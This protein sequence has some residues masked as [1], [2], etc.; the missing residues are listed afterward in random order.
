MTDPIK[1]IWKYKNNNRRSQYAMYIFVGDVAKPIKKILD[2]IAD[3]NFYDSLLNL[4][5]EEYKQLEKLYSDKWYN[6]LFNMYHINSSIY[7]IKDSSVLK[8][9]LVQKYSQQWFDT[10]IS[11][12]ELIEKKLIYSYESIIKYDLER[13]NKKK[14]RESN[15][16]KEAE[17]FNDYTTTKKLDVKKLFAIKEQ[18]KGGRSNKFT[19]LD[20][21]EDFNLSGG[22]GALD[23]SLDY[24]SSY[25][26]SIYG[27]YDDDHN[28]DDHD[29]EDIYRKNKNKDDDNQDDDEDDDDIKKKVKDDQE[30]DEG[31]DDDGELATETMSE[32]E[33]VDLNEIEQIYKDT[34]AK[35]D[36]NVTKT[37]ALIKE[38]LND[39]KIFEKN[40]DNMISFDQ[41]KDN[42]I[43]DENIKDIFKKHYVTSQYIFKDDTIKIIKDKICTSI[44][45]NASFGDQSY[46]LPSR[47]YLWSEYYYGDKIEKIM[48]GQKWLRRNE[49]LTIDIE[50]NNNLRLYEDLEGQ[51]KTLR[52]N[53]KRYTSKIR[54]E[55]DENNILFDYDDYI[56]NNEIYMLDLYNEFGKKYKKDTEVLKNLQDV[57]LK[58]YFPKVRT[59]ELKNILD[60]LNNSDDKVE[61]Q[62][63]I[64]VYE[65][66]S[67]DLI[68]ENEITSMVENIKLKDNFTRGFKTTYVIQSIIHLKLRQ[69][70]PDNKI[71]LYR[72]F[73]EFIVDKKYPFISY[74]TIDGN[75]VYKS[76]EQM[77][78]EFMKKSDN[79]E[80]ITK[81]YE[82]VPYGISIKFKI[83]DKFGE[84]FMGVTISDSGRI[85][86]KIVW[87]EE[88]MAVIEDIK[89][90]YGHVRDIIKKINLEKNRHKFEDPEDS[91]FKYAFINTIQQFEL[92]EK[93]IIDHNDLSDFSRFFYPYVALQIDPKKRQSKGGEKEEEFSKYGTFLRY[94]RVSKYDNQTRIEQRIL[95]FLRNYDITDNVLVNEIS[96]QFNITTEKADEEVQRIKQRYPYLKKSRKI[97]KKLETI[98]KY[99]SPGINIDIIGKQREKYKIRISGVRD[100]E[101]LD[102]MIQFMNILI[103]LYTETY[104]YKKP[105]LQ[106]LKEKLKKLTKIA[107][108]RNKVNDFVQ[109]E[110]DA[111]VVKQMAKMDKERIGYKPEEGQ[112]QWT[113]CCQNSGDGKKRRPQQ[114]NGSNMADLLKKGYKLNKKTGEFERRVFVKNSKSKKK[115]EVL[116]KTLKFADFDAE[117]HPTGNEIH[118]A[119][120]PEENGEH[121]YVGFL[122]KCRNPFGHC[123]PCCF[124]KDPAATKNKGK[125]SFYKTCQ[126]DDSKDT[127][128][129][130]KGDDE[131]DE[132]DEKKLLEQLYILQDT[133]KIQD[134]RFGLLPNYLDFYFNVMLEKDKF[135]KQH[136]LSKTKN[137][138]FFKYGSVQD[139]YQFLNAIGSCINMSVEDILKKIT[140]ILEKDHTEQLY[141]SLNNGDIKSQFGNKTQ[142]IDFINTNPI[143]D[144][145]LLNNIL[146][147]PGTIFKNGM[148]IIVFNKKSI[149]IS[150]TFEKE[151]IREDF[152]VLCGNIEDYYSLTSNRENIFLLKDGKHYYPIVL[153]EKNNENDKN[154][155][156]H[157]TFK[158]ENNKTNIVKHI[159]EF[160]QKNC[161]GSFMDAIIHRESLPT[162]REVLFYLNQ[163]ENKK[164]EPKYQIIDT[165]NKCKFFVTDNNTLIPT[166]PSGS[167]YN[168]QIV[169]SAEKY[170]KSFKETYGDLNEIF[171]LTEEKLDIKP[172]MVYYND[173]DSKNLTVTAIVTKSLDVV[174]VIEEKIKIEDIEKLGLKHENMPIVDKIDNDIVK[175]KTNVKADERVMNVNQDLYLTESYELFRLE[176]SNYL[177]RIENQSLKTKIE[178]IINNKKYTINDKTENIRLILYKLVDKQ[179]HDK[180]KKIIQSKNVVVDEDT[181]IEVDETAAEDDDQEVKQKGGK[182]DKLV[183]IRKDLPDTKSYVINNDRESCNIHKKAE[184][185]ND[186]I[187]CH[188]TR[189]GCYMSLT[190]KMVIKFINK[191]SD[192]LAVGDRK[193]FEILKFEDYYVSDIVDYSKF[194]IRSGQ[195]IIRSTG[196]NVKKA[197]GDIFGAD[198]I[199]VIGKKRIKTTVEG[200]YQ[201][202]NQEFALIDM[203]EYYL[204]KVIMNNL[205]IFRAYVNG[206]Y[207]LKNKYNDPEVKNLGYYSPLQTELSNY[208]RGV[209]IEWLK[210]TKN[211][212]KVEEL[213]QYMHLKKS[214]DIN[215]YII[216]IGS[217]TNYVSNYMVELNI[218]SHINNI[219]IIIFDEINIPIYVFDK[220][221][222]YDRTKNKESEIKKYLD[223]KGSS[224][225]IRFVYVMNNE[226]P[227]TI[228]VIYFK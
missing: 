77:I 164:Y 39:N 7:S 72:I 33:E 137:G 227:D 161:K 220:G 167:I 61:S 2:K 210:T 215:D 54:R 205:S 82:N 20:I 190:K 162:A 88:D 195:K 116:L 202:L 172:Y 73:N 75:I 83:S 221:L 34:D 74:Q 148:N 146:C 163:I 22:F 69:K 57:Y 29:D 218:L 149:I 193:A 70:N 181:D 105:D 170:I 19:S 59:D 13:K 176:F 200:N 124:K 127:G 222:V 67:N 204:Q 196:S 16:S 92:P 64:N 118:Y 138:Y 11:S 38:A 191:V 203:K 114:Y 41:T 169:K 6:K 89:A 37:A 126:G 119:C 14:L 60:Y 81:W 80:T 187:H 121:F 122:T 112:N 132:V 123:M 65:T 125:I 165:R 226:I 151:R 31:D 71:D 94:K 85:E 206:Y 78:N 36:E 184:E 113:R 97:L 150:K 43:Y 211:A 189:T 157:K 26:N 208:F 21:Q 32:D 17:D 228:E 18:Q 133:N 147:I 197:L 53:L 111:K 207:W 217:S 194:T 142:F 108:R 154:I 63:M 50:P 23:E 173:S 4:T 107:K 12:H 134:G 152:E 58:I 213:T 51:L 52:D 185:C 131:D 100:K 48:L 214:K 178:K 160:Y 102:R 93:F 56:Q 106:E 144:F 15:F 174:P 46:V 84:R 201:Q 86:Y 109:Y 158:Y 95:Y 30:D 216:K 177:N 159:S 103:Y 143:L 175:Q 90:T 115:E 62:R 55:D 155:L 96:R 42:N 40:T 136:Y 47:Q 141:T 8:N 120:D 140:N 192:E 76:N 223:T 98:P 66:L 3:L 156:I 25:L 182:Y 166:R 128:K 139:R 198:N 224:I 5:K 45:N 44:K 225:C 180:Y 183:H 209:I 68:I 171:K 130:S 27:G 10:H 168:I 179:S 117:G 79:L 49:I 110:S 1:L 188:W 91:E 99:K 101:Q 199:P 153:V 219:P 212:K 28:D 129:G 135:I 35:H 145:D 9:E 87:K 186:N 24:K 104:L